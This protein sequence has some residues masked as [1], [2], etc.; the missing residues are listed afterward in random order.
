MGANKV[1]RKSPQQAPIDAANLEHTLVN[2][3]LK[4]KPYILPIVIVLGVALLTVVGIAYF[5]HKKGMQN[6][7]A[8]Y[9]L[10]QALAEDA[11][12]KKTDANEEDKEKAKK[13][14]LEKLIKDFP[15]S[16]AVK[17]TRFYLA[18]VNFSLGKLNEA[19]TQFAEFYKKYPNYEPF[20]TSARMAEANCLIAKN[21]FLDAKTKL[22]AITT[23]SRLISTNAGIVASAT[24]KTALCDFLLGKYE[25]AKTTL[26]SLLAS[27]D[28]EYM[29]E[30]AQSFLA[31]MEIIPPNDMKNAIISGEEYS[32][33]G[34][35][36]A[37]ELDDSAEQ[38]KI[39][40]PDDTLKDTVE[41]TGIED[42]D[43]ELQGSG[44]EIQPVDNGAES[45]EDVKTVAPGNPMK[46]AVK[47]LETIDVVDEPKDSSDQVEVIDS[48]VDKLKDVAEQGK[49]AD[50]VK[51][52][53]DA[54]EQIKS[55]D[56]GEKLPNAS[57]AVGSIESGVNKVKDAVEQAETADSAE[58][59]KDTADQ[60]KEAGRS[61][62]VIPPGEEGV[63]RK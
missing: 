25:D 58:E 60:M 18:K 46:E 21:N 50:G 47:Q 57:K 11:G 5:R 22:Q 63:K 36:S 13:E 45:V 14:K 55:I 39:E 54:T 40:Q 42:V 17:D 32:S 26:N 27:S 34:A 43:T 33:V 10:H 52:L 4:T 1:N 16:P 37:E 31:K 29:K 2:W 59:L 48:A 30:K 38:S 6:A 8:Y 35:G 24:Y 23:D 56:P 19:A 41:Q 12:A 15:G 51:D 20:S 44:K 7:E 61:L 3:F 9:A 28:D 53:K 62:E 49:T